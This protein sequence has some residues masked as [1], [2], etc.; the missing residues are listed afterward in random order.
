MVG[1]EKGCAIYLPLENRHRTVFV[2]VKELDRSLYET[3]WR[4]VVLKRRGLIE[5]ASG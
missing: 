4:R 5:S 2:Q 3:K 1:M